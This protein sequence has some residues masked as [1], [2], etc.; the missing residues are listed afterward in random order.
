MREV[1]VTQLP[2]EIIVALIGKSHPTFD[3]QTDI[4]FVGNIG[5]KVNKFLDYQYLQLLAVI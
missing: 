5:A 3:L 2:I 1:S 4:I